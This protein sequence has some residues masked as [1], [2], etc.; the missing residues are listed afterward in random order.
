[1]IVKDPIYRMALRIWCYNHVRGADVTRHLNNFNTKN[2]SEQEADA[3][4]QLLV[5][6]GEKTGNMW[7]PE[8][9]N[10]TK[11][12]TGFANRIHS[13][14]AARIYFSQLILK[15][16]LYE[17]FFWTMSSRE[18]GKEVV[19]DPTG[20]P[21]NLANPSID[22]IEPYFGLMESAPEGH[23]KVYSNLVD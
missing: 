11:N 21:R 14:T 23:R 2:L 10:A 19:L 6:L 16:S 9:C 15:R 8:C 3:V 5:R 22:I 1:M 18:D 20:V 4:Y 13:Q 12:L 7:M 17:H